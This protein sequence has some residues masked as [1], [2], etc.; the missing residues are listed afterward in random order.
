MRQNPIAI[1]ALL[2]VQFPI[3]AAEPAGIMTS[4]PIGPQHHGDPV[5]FRQ[6]WVK[7]L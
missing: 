7:S 2:A 4:G 6:L 1:L 3:L 5:Q